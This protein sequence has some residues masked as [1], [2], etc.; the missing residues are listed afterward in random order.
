MQDAIFVRLA[1]SHYQ[2]LLATNLAD[3]ARERIAARLAKAECV[4]A[5]R[6]AAPRGRSRG[7]RAKGQTSLTI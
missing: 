6:T 1:I 7:S 5:R 2:A 3:R 4:L